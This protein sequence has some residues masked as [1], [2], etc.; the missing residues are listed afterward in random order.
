MNKKSIQINLISPFSNLQMNK[1][2]LD[3]NM[4]MK[5]QVKPDAKNVTVRVLEIDQPDL[6]L[7]REFLLEGFNH[8]DVQSYLRYMMETVEL[9]APDKDVEGK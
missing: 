6:G 1:L 5:F 8:E 3:I 7:E 9:I 4:L 2:G